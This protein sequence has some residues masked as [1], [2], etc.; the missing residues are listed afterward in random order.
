MYIAIVKLINHLFLVVA[1]ALPLH[2]ADGQTVVVKSSSLEGTIVLLTANVAGKDTEF[3]CVVN[4]PPCT[5]APAG[6]YFMV[7][8]KDAE[9]VYEDCTNVVLYRTDPSRKDKV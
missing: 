2:A 4:S 9:G 1:V 6:E 5:A 8:A 7:R 3:T